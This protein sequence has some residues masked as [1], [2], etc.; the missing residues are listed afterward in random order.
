MSSHSQHEIY[1]CDS[2]VHLV[3][4]DN[5]LDAFNRAAEQAGFISNL[6]KWWQLSNKAKK[7][8]RIAIKPNIMTASKYEVDS[9]VYTDPALV[10]ELI[11]LMRA[12][13]FTSFVVVESQNVYNYSYTGRAVEKV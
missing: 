13:G 3:T 2:A 9:P 11:R 12:E 4:A 1:S 7:D 5:K 8:F 6:L 10:E